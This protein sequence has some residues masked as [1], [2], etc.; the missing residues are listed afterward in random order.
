MAHVMVGL[1][2]LLLR[3][4]CRKLRTPVFWSDLVSPYGAGPTAS[5]GTLWVRGMWASLGETTEARFSSISSQEK[6]E[7]KNTIEGK[8]ASIQ[9]THGSVSP[10]LRESIGV[11]V[12][13]HHKSTHFIKHTI[14]YYPSS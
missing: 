11:R 13:L 2:V 8:K 14:N 6:K 7:K 5:S 4:L 3:L 1:E 12:V 9:Y 10:L